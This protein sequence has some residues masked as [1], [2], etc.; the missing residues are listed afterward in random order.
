MAVLLLEC[1]RADFEHDEAEAGAIRQALSSQ[2]GL[3]A[4]E[5]DRLLG[6]AGQAARSA[7]SLHGPVSR[8]NDT[9]SADQ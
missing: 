4:A 7:V 6:E 3:E 1:A 9:L 5:V 2:L 8:L